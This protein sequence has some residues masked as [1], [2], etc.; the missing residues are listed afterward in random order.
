MVDDDY[1]T[2]ETLKELIEIEGGTVEA[3]ESA[4][5]FLKAYHPGRKG[6]LVVDAKMPGMSGLALLDRL[7][8]D[9]DRLPAIMITAHGD[10]ATAVHAM[11]AGAADL[12]EKPVSPEELLATLE[13]VIRQSESAVER[14]SWHA[15][16]AKR[17]AG[18]TDRQ[19]EI[20][21][22]VVAGHANKEIAA[23]LNINQ[24][25]VESHRALIMKKTGAAS[26]A[27]LVRLAL[28]VDF[29]S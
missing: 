27:D 29:P 5:A 9:G 3:Y 11:K 20:M 16:Q 14:A 23:R 15:V 28:A 4:D 25:T 26:F 12:I 6:C 1:G 21:R 24:R 8:D 13:R 2:R 22:L 18:L 10:A 19:R 7:R 17:V